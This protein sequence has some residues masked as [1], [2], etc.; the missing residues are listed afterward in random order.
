[1]ATTNKELEIEINKLKEQNRV[2]AQ[3]LGLSSESVAEDV[4]DRKDYVGH[5]SPEYALFLG[6][7]EVLEDDMADAKIN[8]YIL[9][10]SPLTGKTW[11]LE[12]EVSPF[13]AFANP[14][15]IAKLYLR[16]KVSS[17]ES[18]KP[19][20]PAGAPSLLVPRTAF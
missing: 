1:M 12:D 10:E 17:L 16:Q 15:K 3:L 18:G 14:D 5:G 20:V 11:R 19:S 8:E 4:T 7:I 2:M 6:L 13:M 9:Y